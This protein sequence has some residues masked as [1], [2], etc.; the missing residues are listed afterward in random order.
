M[1]YT[2]NRSQRQETKAIQLQVQP[3]NT[4]GIQKVKLYSV[5]GSGNENY[6]LC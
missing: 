6:T 5:F 4:T 3:N 2:A 1:P